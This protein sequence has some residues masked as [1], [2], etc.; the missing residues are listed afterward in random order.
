MT[1]LNSTARKIDTLFKI[2][3][4]LLSIAGIAL[5][6]G[7]AVIGATFLF[8]LDPAMV[9]TGYNTISLGCL[10]LRIADMYAPDPY[11][12]LK[13]MAAQMVLALV[14]IFVIRLCVKCIRQILK[15]MVENKP[16]DATVSVNLKKLAKYAL[17]LGITVNVIELLS[18]IALVR[19]YD[20]DLLIMH[21]T[22][23]HAEFQF[24][25]DFSF[26]P[27]WGL[28]LLLSYVFRYGEELQQLSDETL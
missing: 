23:P 24:T 11:H 2:F 26:L 15:P 20:L 1:K 14:V 12:V 7:L 18:S 13:V 25:F 8:K 3:T 5:L 10:K 4:V 21:E 22:I 19:G 17:I 9:G 6:A 27:V 16:F 28:L